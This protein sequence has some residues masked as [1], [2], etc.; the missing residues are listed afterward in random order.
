MDLEGRMQRSSLCDHAIARR[1]SLQRARS[2]FKP[3]SIGIRSAISDRLPQDCSDRRLQHGAYLDVAGRRSRQVKRHAVRCGGLK[4]V[5]DC[6][7]DAW[8][9]A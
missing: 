9:D 5:T 3:V 1:P 7:R 2:Q 4:Y 8:P 6:I